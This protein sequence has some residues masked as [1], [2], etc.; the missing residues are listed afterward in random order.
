MKALVVPKLMISAAM[1][2]A[3]AARTRTEIDGLPR[4]YEQSA[5]S[6]KTSPELS[7]RLAR[8][9]RRSFRAWHK[10][11]RGSAARSRARAHRRR[12][13]PLLVKWSHRFVACGV[14]APKQPTARVCA[15]RAPQ[16]SLPTSSNPRRARDP[17]G[18]RLLSGGPRCSRRAR[19]RSGRVVL[20]RRTALAGDH[21]DIP[22]SRRVHSR[23]VGNCPARHRDRDVSGDKAIAGRASSAVIT[24][25]LALRSH[26]I[27]EYPRNWQLS[28]R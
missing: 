15:V 17:R 6:A 27:V 16:S 1:P 24:E 10:W 13:S 25:S 7:K 9:V 21:V 3:A 18:A 26:A 5:C 20:L 11:V 14:F 4:L 23:P 8:D 22:R 2:A 12:A 19:S 28:W